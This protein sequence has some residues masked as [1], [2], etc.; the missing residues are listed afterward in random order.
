MTNYLTLIILSF[1]SCLVFQDV[2]ILYI[3]YKASTRGSFKKIVIRK[4]STFISDRG[5][6]SKKVTK[7]SDWVFLNQEIGQLGLKKLDLIE[8]PTDKRYSDRAL[9]A[10]LS[11]ATKNHLYHSNEFDHGNPPEPIKQMVTV[12]TKYLPSE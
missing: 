3:E 12:L 6:E 7:E 8:A 10:Q 5:N 9:S 2:E 1:F 11:V 4:D